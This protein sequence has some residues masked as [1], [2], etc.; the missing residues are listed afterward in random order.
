MGLLSYM[1]GDTLRGE[2]WGPAD[3]RWYAP[4]GAGTITPAGM[5]VDAESA[6]KISAWYRGRDI[7]ATVLAMLP[8]NVM[9]QLP[10][11]GGSKVAQGHP[12]HGRL[13]DQPNE[14]Q[15]AFEWKRQ[16]MYDLIDTG[17]TYDWIVPGRH[18]FVDE[19]H[20][21]ATA[22]IPNGPRQILSG[23]FKGRYLFDVRDE[24][25]GQT[26]THTQ[27]EIFHLQGAEGKGILACARQSL[28]TA[29]ATETYAASI[30][31]KGTLNGGVIE[32]PG[33][34]DPEASKRMAR[35]FVTA[36]GEWHLPKVLEQGA[37]WNNQHLLTPEDAQMLLSRKFS[38]D[39]MARWLGVPRQMLEN[40]DP[41]F[42]NAEQFNQAFIDFTMGPWLALWEFGINRQ[43]ILVDKYFAQ[44]KRQAL[45][46]GNMTA[47]AT[48]VI[49]Y[50][51][52]GLMSVDEGRGIED[53]PKRGGKADELRTPQNITGKP[54]V[55]GEEPPADDAAPK[56]PP[57]KT[58]PPDEEDAPRKRARAIVTESAA[59]V[60]RKEVQAAQKAA[61]KYADN[62]EAWEAFV[63]RFYA[64]HYPLVMQTMLLDESTAKGYCA[65][66]CAELHDGLA[67]TEAWTP[68]YLASMALDLER[69]EPAPVFHSHTTIAEGA[70]Q[71]HIAPAAVHHHQAPTTVH[72]PVTIA[73]GAVRVDA[74]VTIADGAIQTHLTTA[75]AKPT[76]VEKTVT[77]DPK[78]QITRV[79]EQHREQ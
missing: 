27:D 30:F 23:A 22:C 60:L 55:E 32:T 15:D 63:D 39:D 12:L 68:A 45:L 47:R 2:T 4:I 44:F 24:K 10:D 54:K 71:T 72:A 79:T 69:P 74:P 64:E 67:V 37:K 33:V 3:D 66:Q 51:N 43:L 73:E 53:L 46:R 1:L 25:T 40:S 77:R 41:S 52:A 9:E 7:L 6:K 13:H 70:V 19:L 21:I 42:G 38:I 49:G 56:P 36:A 65:L 28:G 5:R 35:S 16:K 34:M 11:D 48:A 78:G 14:F 8:L 26:T 50:V 29:I 58:G 20:P 61:V 18:G 31:G 75:P 76:V 17:H 59:R 62:A 57:K